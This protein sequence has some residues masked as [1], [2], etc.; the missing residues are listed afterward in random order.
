M[1]GKGAWWLLCIAA[2]FVTV[3]L[4]MDRVAQRDAALAR[5]VPELFRGFA[6]VQLA[7]AALQSDQP[8]SAYPYAQSLI[9]RRPIA[10]EHLSILSLAAAQTERT[11]I[12]N[13]AILLAAGRGWR[14]PLAQR[15]VVQ[16]AV[17]A[18]DWDVAVD[19]VVALWRAD[20]D[21]TVIAEATRNVLADSRGRAAFA[22]RLAESPYWQRWFLDWGSTELSSSLFAPTVALSVRAGG[23]FN[24][25]ALSVA[26]LRAV[27]NGYAADAAMIWDGSCAY[28]ASGNAASLV[29]RPEVVGSS[30]GPFDWTYPSNA[31]L[32]RDWREGAQGWSL[33]YEN[34]S[35]AK[36][37]LARK[38]VRLAPGERR[39]RLVVDGGRET[40]HSPADLRLFC[41]AEGGARSKL[42]MDTAAITFRV[43]VQGCEV[44]L[45][46]VRVPRGTEK[47]LRLIAN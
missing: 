33:D 42:A 32:S 2:A 43:P 11:D 23:A 28:G 41:V 26:A 38:F 15:V 21:R 24:C 47:G 8:R 4:Q 29:F 7:L 45:L 27:R 19:R 22:A 34:T 40:A 16:A 9:T 18:D 1:F 30:E 3:L 13:E 5:S 25:E 35:P 6:D 14:E 10:A 12:A 31:G 17:A 44:Q 37:V 46:D 20:R 36:A 39:I